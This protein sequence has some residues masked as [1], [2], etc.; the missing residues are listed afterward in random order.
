MNIANILMG[1]VFASVRP[2]LQKFS[3]AFYN[4][5]TY[6][7]TLAT[8]GN[9]LYIDHFGSNATAFLN[10]S[11]LPTDALVFNSFNW[12]RHYALMYEGVSGS[13]RYKI[14]TTTVAG[15]Q[16]SVFVTPEVYRP[17]SGL[18][19]SEPVIPVMTD[20]T[21]VEPSDTGRAA[22]FTIPYY[23]NKYS[24]PCRYWQVNSTRIAAN[25]NATLLRVDR[26]TLRDATT[27][28]TCTSANAD[29]HVFTA[30]GP[31]SK[32]TM[33]R[34]VPGIQ[35]NSGTGTGMVSWSVQ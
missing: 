35:V 14:F 27:L 7:A 30:G 17:P 25:G 11:I 9:T 8:N 24:V 22:E 32:F 3:R 6:A 26:I 5:P 16:P 15:S 13:T 28:A 2:F 1:E 23:S 10:T 34:R 20:F 29:F 33:F 31:D 18:T 19:I 4:S 12:F 21:L